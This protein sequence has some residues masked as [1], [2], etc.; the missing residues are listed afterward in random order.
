MVPSQRSPDHKQS[1]A[2]EACWAHNPEVRRSKLRSARREFLSMENAFFIK[3]P[4]QTRNSRFYVPFKHIALFLCCL[5]CFKRSDSF[6][7]SQGND[8]ECLIP[9]TKMTSKPRISSQ[10]PNWTVT[11]SW[12]LVSSL[13][14]SNQPWIRRLVQRLRNSMLFTING[15]SYSYTNGHFRTF[16][17][18]FFQTRTTTSFI[19]HYLRKIHHILLPELHSGWAGLLDESLATIKLS[20]LQISV[21]SSIQNR[22]KRD[23]G[24][25]RAKTECTDDW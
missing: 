19:Y 25:K 3:M 8:L 1:G 12:W 5:K 23:P 20:N 10:F 15:F 6:T 9:Q 4:R 17:V 14:A 7:P 18:G 13:I 21:F 2:A 24:V 11:I 16:H 22:G